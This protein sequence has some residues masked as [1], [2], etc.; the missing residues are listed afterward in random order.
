MSKQV[1]AGIKI[2]LVS[3]IWMVIEAVV[4]IWSG[5]AAGSALL[6]A[7]G[8]DSIIELVSAGV[9]SGYG[10]YA[11]IKPENSLYGSI[12]A[13]AAAI[14]MPL[15]SRQKKKIAAMIGSKALAADA[16]CTMVCAYMA[17]SVLLGLL[18]NYLFGWWWAEHIAALLFLY[19][20][21]KET[22][23]AFDVARNKTN[24]CSCC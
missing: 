23:E 22:K 16:S 20:L 10:L 13:A 1:N 14:G 3:I 18:L 24:G 8:M 11:R 4:S 15:L 12:I 17:L 9:L 21:Y 6:T 2:E 5:V 7:F 19:W